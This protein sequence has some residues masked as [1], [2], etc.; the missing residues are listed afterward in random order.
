MVRALIDGHKSQSRRLV[1]FGVSHECD[2]EHPHWISRDGPHDWHCAT[3]GSGIRDAKV[4]FQGLACPFGQVGDLLWAREAWRLHGRFSD[5]ARIVYAASE[6]RSWTE[7]HDDFPV[8]LAASLKQRDGWRSSI[9]MPRWASRLTLEI[10]EIRI[11]RLAT[12]SRDDAIAEGATSRP[13][14]YGLGTAHDGWSM[15]WSRLGQTDRTSGLPLTERDIS[16][17]TPETAFENFIN[18]LHGGP[19]WNFYYNG[20]RRYPQPIFET[21]PWVWAVSFVVH[22]LHVDAVLSSREAA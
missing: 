15:D 12:I 20:D 17:C 21:N 11:E 13:N 6:R 2:C 10:T 16:L 14:S 19:K 3:C 4:N 18:E 1:K 8:R 5:V 22:R 7:A 9:H